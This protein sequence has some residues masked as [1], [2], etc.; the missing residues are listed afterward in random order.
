M[1]PAS[2]CS[3]SATARR[4]RSN[5]AEV[6]RPSARRRRLPFEALRVGVV[7]HVDDQRAVLVDEQRRAR[8]GRCAAHEA[9]PA[10][11]RA[12]AAG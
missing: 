1:T 12:T 9:K 7:G 4:R 11:G 10:A 5:S 6:K 2:A 8:G 3:R